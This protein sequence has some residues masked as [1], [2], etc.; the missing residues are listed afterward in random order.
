MAR[1]NKG[2][3]ITLEGIEGCGK[4]TQLKSIARYFKDTKRPYI[5]VRE[6]GGTKIGEKIRTILL[7]KKNTAMS[8]ETEALLY[9]AARA[10]IV[11]EVIMPALAKGIS[12]ICDR[13]Y[14]STLAYQGYGL[15]MKMKTLTDL[16]L[17]ASRRLV[18]DMTILLD[19]SVTIGLKRAGRTDRIEG[20]SLAYHRKVRSGFLDL[21]R[22]NKKR[23]F[24]LNGA[25]AI[26]AVEKEIKGI[27]DHAIK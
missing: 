24:V 19:L 17:F 23:F 16:C 12:V 22:K 10:Q 26:G 4:S 1:K 27:L 15:G 8:Y 25:H 3:F 21:A 6:P 14:D 13:F 20:R 5:I 2:Y 9:C 11:D 18:P 7:D